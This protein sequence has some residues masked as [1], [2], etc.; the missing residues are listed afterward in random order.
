MSQKCNMSL[1]ILHFVVT[2]KV[3]RLDLHFKLLLHLSSAPDAL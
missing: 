1:R 3:K 2:L